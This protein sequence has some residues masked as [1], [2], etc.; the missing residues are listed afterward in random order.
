MIQ[1]TGEEF[2]YRVSRLAFLRGY[3]CRPR[4]PVRSLFYPDK[5]Q[6]SD[7]DVM[8]VKFDVNLNKTTTIWECKTGSDSAIDRIMWLL[9]F[10]DFCKADLKILVKPQIANRIKAFGLEVGVACWDNDF[11]S[12]RE[13]AFVDCPF[14]GFHSYKKRYLRN[15]ETYE[16]IRKSDDL[17]SVYWYMA[18]N[19]WF[20]TP[21]TRLKRI[22]SSLQK[23][24]VELDRAN[25]RTRTVSILLLREAAVLA[26]IALL[27]FANSMSIWNQTSDLKDRIALSLQSGLGTPEERRKLINAVLTYAEE[28][29]GKKFPQSVRY[30]LESTP[31]PSYTDALVNHIERIIEHPDFAVHVPRFLEIMA[32]DLNGHVEGEDKKNVENFLNADI[33]MIAKLARNLI[34]FLEHSTSFPPDILKTVTQF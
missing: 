18:S 23:L 8:G 15:P 16:M 20:D 6:V 29:C 31:S 1:F 19:F 24:K 34:G 14:F 27:D 17:H 10:S 32:Y 12:K 5:V 26:S 33:S 25:S 7:V 28:L 13:A 21:E 22:L 30:H 11:L 3:S 2:E 9:G 4:I